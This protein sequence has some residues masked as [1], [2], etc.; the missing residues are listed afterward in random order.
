[1]S[2]VI[3]PTWSDNQTVLATQQL[4]RNAVVSA[5]MDWRTK[6][7][8][9]LMVR[10]GRTGTT[11]L[12]GNGVRVI[13]RPDVNNTTIA[14]PGAVWQNE[15][16]LAAAQST[17]CATSDSNSGQNILTVGSTTSWAAGDFGVLNVNGA[18]E[19]WFRVARVTD[20]THLLLDENL[21]FT[22]TS[23]QADTLRNKAECWTIELPGGTVWRVIVDYGSSTAG[24]TMQVH[25]VAQTMDS[26]AG[27]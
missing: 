1:M 21:Q 7:G 4:A 12:T 22:H 18:R 25:A 8:G 13:V 27:T 15:G 19:E 23:A 3:T 2:T 20:S 16:Q 11:A 24:D 17:T 5:T 14:H 9:R 10:L 6:W 26:V